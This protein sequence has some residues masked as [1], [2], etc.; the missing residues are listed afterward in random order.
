MAELAVVNSTKLNTVVQDELLAAVPDMT[1]WSKQRVLLWRLIKENG[2]KNKTVAQEVGAG[3]STLRRFLTDGTYTPSE[4]FLRKLEEYFRR[5]GIWDSEMTLPEEQPE[6]FTRIGQ[7]NVVVTD[8]WKRTWFVLDNTLK[9]QNFGMVVG[10]SG[11]GK[12]SAAKYWSEEPANQD[13]AIFITAN[14][15]M[16]RKA[17]L[18]RIAKG[19]GVWSSGDSDVLLERICAE[20]AERP[21]LIIIDEADQISSKMKLE[22]LRS[23][24]DN[25]GKIGIVLI[26]NEDLSEYILQIASDDRKLSRIHN[27]FGAYQQVKMPNRDEA[28]KMLEGFNLTTGAREYLI[29]VMQRRSGKGGI[30]VVRTMLAIVLEALGDKLITETILRSSSLE[31]AVLSVKG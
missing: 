5:I 10:P 20:L 13:R 16:T 30:R 4:E 12:T 31:N 8:A 7:M 2:T 15:C 19:V 27:R 29:N 18:R 1:G 21:R 26:G 3:E 17:I 24:L 22:A 28:I 25:T 11:C 9:H 23:I 6:F 14:G